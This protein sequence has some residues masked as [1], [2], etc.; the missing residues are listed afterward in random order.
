MNL[1]L[2]CVMFFV[3]KGSF[4]ARKAVTHDY[5][6]ANLFADNPLTDDY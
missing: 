4:P 5:N 6:L 2:F 3:K 1:F